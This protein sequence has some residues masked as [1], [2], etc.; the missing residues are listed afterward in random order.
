MLRGYRQMIVV[1]DAMWESYIRTDARTDQAIGT[2]AHTATDI[3]EELHVK[4]VANERNPKKG[5]NDNGCKV[6]ASLDKMDVSSTQSQPSNPN[7]VD[8]T[9]PKKK[10]KKKSSEARG[11]NSSTSLIDAAMLLGDNIRI[12]D[13]EL[14]RS[15]ASEIEVRNDHL[16]K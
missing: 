3:F 14:R 16:R 8:S 10:K 6:D 4:D 7:K 13:L 11:S 1:E 15:I 9:F 2:D 5:S 12:V